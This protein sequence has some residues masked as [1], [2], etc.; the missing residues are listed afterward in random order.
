[1][2]APTAEPLAST[3]LHHIVFSSPSGSAV[4]PPA[5]CPSAGGVVSSPTNS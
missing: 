5:G 1:M 3:V 4:G 2:T